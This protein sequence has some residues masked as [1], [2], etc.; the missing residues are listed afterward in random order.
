M[1]RQQQQQAARQEQ[2]MR[3]QLAES[4]ASREVMAKA[5]KIGQERADAAMVKAEERRKE[6]EENQAVLKAR[7][8]SVRMKAELA[9]SDTTRG[10][11]GLKIDKRANQKAPTFSMNPIDSLVNLPM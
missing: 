7:A 3:Q 9:A 1:L 5:N 8:D 6:A 2:L 10:R 11:Q 4:Q